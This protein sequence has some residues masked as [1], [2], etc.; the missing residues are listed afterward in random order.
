[1]VNIILLMYLK[2]FLLNRVEKKERQKER[3]KIR[4]KEKEKQK[5]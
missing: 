5:N 4:Q 2:L 3:Q 1:M